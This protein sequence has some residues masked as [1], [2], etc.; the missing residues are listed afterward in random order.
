MTSADPAVRLDAITKSFGGRRVLNQVTLE[1][2]EGC[3]FVILGRSG[4]GKSV[5]LRHI[6]GLVRPD[7]GSVFVHGTD[8]TELEGTELAEVRK[9]V[10]F[11]FQSG[12]LFDSISV[13]ENVAFPMRRHTRLADAEIRQRVQSKLDSVGLGSDY[14]KMPGDLSGGM[15]KRAGLARAMALDPRILLV[16]EPSAG[17]DP[18]TSEEIDELLLGLKQNQKTTLVVV[19]HNIPS[20][21]KLGDQLVMLDQGRSV[22]QGTVEEL[23]QSDNELVRAFMSSSHAG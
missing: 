17:L 5:A 15:R 12:A 7:A 16:D 22:A 10:G 18:I 4:T 20:A 21:R 1:V 3:G 9:Q 6:I 11:L 23:E 14:D 19:T 2:P 8:I 13:G